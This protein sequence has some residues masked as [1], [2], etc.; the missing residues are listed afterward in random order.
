MTKIETEL[1]ELLESAAIEF[2]ERRRPDGARFDK[3][4][5]DITDTFLAEAAARALKYWDKVSSRLKSR[6]ATQYGVTYN[7]NASERFQPKWLLDQ[8]AIMANL[9]KYPFFAPFLDYLF[10]LTDRPGK[11]FN[12]IKA[13]AKGRMHTRIIESGPNKGKVEKYHYAAFQTS[14]DFYK[15]VKANVFDSTGSRSRPLKKENAKKYVQAFSRAGLIKELR[16]PSDGKIYSDGWYFIDPLGKIIKHKY[17]N[18][19]NSEIKEALRA[20]SL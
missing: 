17:L 12:R 1:Y 8:K 5:I 20:F 2:I 18:S 4:G 11:N 13:L 10:D 16:Y 3:D 6:I 19:T 7:F 15:H 14:A 9:K